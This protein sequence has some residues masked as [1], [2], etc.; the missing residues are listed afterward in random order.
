[1]AARGENPF[2][3]KHGCVSGTAHPSFPAV[4]YRG[5]VKK[6]C[7][8]LLS[9]CL[10]TPLANATWSIILVDH[11]TG[12]VAIASAT[13][14]TNFSLELFVPAIVVGKGALAAQ[15]AVDAGGGNRMIGVDL[16]IADATPDDVLNA[17]LTIGST[18]NSRQYGIAAFSGPAATYSGSVAG[19]ALGNVVGQIGTITYAIQGNV[20][21]GS[22]PVFAAEE[23][24]RGTDGDIGQRMMAA[25]QA[26]KALGGDGRCSCTGADPTGCGVPPPNFT[27]SAHCG[28]VYVARMGDTDG[29][30][31]PAGCANGDYYMALAYSGNF[32]DPDPVDVLQISYD[33]WRL[34][35]QARPD[36]ILSRVALSAD[37]V[38]ADGATAALVTVSLVDLNGTPLTSGG[39]TLSVSLSAES[40][41]DAGIGAVLDNGDGTYSF[42]V[43]A[44]SLVGLA[45]LVIIA[46]DGVEA[47]TIYP[48]PTLQVETLQAMHVGRL[49]LDPLLGGSVPLT[50]NAPQS[51]GG[52]MIVLAS[53]SGTVPGLPVGNLNLPLNY[54]PILQ[55]TFS[56]PNTGLLE[57]TLGVLGLNGRAQAR[58]VAPPSLLLPALGL[59]VDWAALHSFNGVNGV[60]NADGFDIRI[61]G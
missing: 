9:F 4:R 58:F 6:L 13:C 56:N 26:A 3:T 14:L 17:L 35:L 46:D 59:R 44:G 57:G 18:P 39:A 20:L 23:A 49:S 48:Y 55:W 8:T 43:S 7:A 16:L 31:G 53:L 5:V 47:A 42:E 11:A 36:G 51:E 28:F 1:M 22:E 60:T 37:S 61:G 12:E 15:S 30:C 45:E 40:T 25:M 21:V 38:P 54:D 24:L 34:A 41:A 10:M 33:A 32:S 2:R 27:K 52:I 19:D 50:V 29:D